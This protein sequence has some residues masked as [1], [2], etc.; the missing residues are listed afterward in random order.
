MKKWTT[1]V[2]AVFV[3]LGIPLLVFLLWR[4]ITGTTQLSCVSNAYSF[5]CY[6]KTVDWLVVA[7]VFEAAA[8]IY[9]WTR[10]RGR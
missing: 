2:I 5:G 6:N 10:F 1:T 8:I 4:T 7:T 9:L 3:V